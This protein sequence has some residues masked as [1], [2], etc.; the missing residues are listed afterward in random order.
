MNFHNVN[1][2]LLNYAWNY[3]ADVIVLIV[4]II[5]LSHR[6]GK[7]DNRVGHRT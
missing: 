4:A 3:A 6:P 5:S 7:R 2:Y 1:V